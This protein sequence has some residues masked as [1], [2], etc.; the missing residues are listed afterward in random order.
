MSWTHFDSTLD[1]SAEKAIGRA[2]SKDWAS[3][4]AAADLRTLLAYT[5]SVVGRLRDA[6]TIGA[7]NRQVVDTSKGN[8]LG[9]AGAEISQ[10]LLGALCVLA[11]EPGTS[12]PQ[13][14]TG[15]FETSKSTQPNAG[16]W[17]VY[18]VVTVSVAVGLAACAWIA[19]EAAPVVDRHVSREASRQDLL[20]AQVQLLRLAKTHAD[21]EE[22]AGKAVP[23]SPAEAAAIAALSQ[24]A[25]VSLEKIKNEKPYVSPSLFS[26][27]AASGLALAALVGFYLFGEKS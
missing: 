23:L 5:V 6:P 24:A 1:A 22:K 12:K 16:A 27:E 10:A 14:F 8:F 26:F 9:I 7:G 13:T 11:V 21:A 2:L 17:P 15:D 19:H 18:V 4:G 3:P 20:Y 25:Q